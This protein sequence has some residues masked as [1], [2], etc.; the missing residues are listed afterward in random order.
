MKV[1]AFKYCDCIF[2]SAWATISIHLD[3]KNAKKALWEH[4]KVSFREHKEYKKYC[5]KEGNDRPNFGWH[6]DWHIGEMEIQ[7]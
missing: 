1:Y 3:R 4:M 2:E 7:P 5:L 6:Q